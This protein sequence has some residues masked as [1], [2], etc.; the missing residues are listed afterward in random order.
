MR[1]DYLGFCSMVLTLFL[2]GTN[3]S[4]S[5][6]EDPL[7]FTSITSKE[8]LSSNIVHAILKDRYGLMWFGTEDGLNKFNGTEF[9]VYRYDPHN[10]FS[11]RSN[12]I[13]SLCEDKAGRLWIGTV[14]GALHR[15]DRNKD[16]FVPYGAGSGKNALSGGNIKGLCSDY[17]GKLW[18]ATL[19]GLNILDPVT[20]IVT[21]FTDN[22]KVAKELRDGIVLCL[23]ED[24]NKRMWIG[25]SS[26][27]YVYDQQKAHFRRFIHQ[28]DDTTSLVSN[29][30]KTI[31]QDKQGR[32]WIGTT[33]GL[34]MLLPGDNGFRNYK[35]S[36]NNTP[37]TSSDVIYSIGVKNTN[38]LWIGSEDGLNILDLHTYHIRQ[39]KPD[40]RNSFALTS[41]SIR[42]ILVDQQGI[43]WLGTY[44]GGVNKYDPNLTFFSLKKSNPFDPYGLSA[45]FVTSFSD[46]SNGNIFV[47]TDGGG[48]N[49]F[50]MQSKLLTHYAIR[51]KG[52][53]EAE[54]LAILSLAKAHDS[55]L[56]IGTYNDGFFKFYPKTGN[57]QQFIKEQTLPTLRQNDVFCLLEDSRGKLWIGTNGSGVDVFDAKTQK[58][59]RD[60]EIPAALD[61]RFLLSNGY[62]RTI[63]EDHNGKI[64]IGSYGN[65]LAVLDPVKRDVVFLDRNNG[66]LPSN[67]INALY[68]DPRGGMWVGTS[69]EGLVRLNPS[70][71]TVAVY[72]EDQGLANGVIHSIL[73]DQ[74][75]R[76]WVSTNVGVSWFDVRT[77][78]FT[79]Y[80]YF[81]GLQ[82]NSFVQGA[83]FTSKQG[84]LFFGGVE[85]INY[86]SPGAIKQNK[87]IPQVM[88][89]DLKLGGRSVT[90]LD[91]SVLS[92][93]ISV[94]KTI[95]L[96][97][98]Q[99]FSLSYVALN[100]TSPRQNQYS[101]RLK[102]FENEWNNAGSKTTANYTNL[103]PG[104]Y[105]FQVRVS[106]N[107]GVWNMRGKEI[108]IIVKP[109]L[110]MTWY[111]CISYFLFAAVLLLYIR[112]RGIRNLQKEFKAHQEKRESERLH[113]LDRLKIK[114]LTNLSHEFRTP[115]SLIMAPVD[116]LLVEPHNEVME[117]Q[118]GLI[119]RNAKRLLNLVNQLLDLRK[120]EEHESKLCTTRGDIVSFSREVS[121]SFKDISEKK[122]I[123]FI[124][125]TDVEKL[126]VYFD[127]DKI[128]R[129]LFNL[130]SNAFKFTTDGGNVSLSVDQD[131]NPTKR[132]VQILNIKVSDTG[133]GIPLEQQERI[134]GRFYQFGTEPAV[135]NQGSGIGLSIA[136]EFV[137][138]HGGTLTVKSEPGLGST[139]LIQLPFDSP[140]EAD[141]HSPYVPLASEVAAVPKPIHEVT[142]DQENDNK[143]AV[144]IVEDN[145][146]FRFYLKD[147]LKI[148]YKV[149]EAKDGKEGWQKAL[150]QHPDLV[151][152]D[153]MMPHMNGTALSLKL[154]SD[155]RTAHIPVILLTASTG[156]EEELRGLNSGANDYLTKPFKFDILNAKVKNLLSYN[157]MLKKT[158][159]KQVHLSPVEVQVESGNEAFVKAVASYIEENI[160]N[161]EL[162]VQNI[163]HHVSMS[164]GSL[165]NKLLE[166]TGQTPIEFIR[167][168]KLEKAAFLLEK[169]DMNI[170]QIAYA[171]GF[172]TPNYFAKSFKDK[173]GL[174]PSDYIK[175]K[176][177]LALIDNTRDR[178][179]D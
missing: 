5:A 177:K 141:E 38:E 166:T 53:G 147:N 159:V 161:R 102:G 29:T 85:G 87:H 3:L 168:M 41:K 17:K 129:V 119:Q 162:S 68:A 66:R 56:W 151:I 35:H 83:G 16:W 52:R 63:V 107:D 165:Y 140:D 14:G 31:T 113:E 25:T 89:T 48:L 133:I 171:V 50:H 44:E 132:Q 139:F 152:S 120:M 106:N 98:K 55:G 21:K 71:K 23:F 94:A 72:G 30:V 122:N 126:V 179:N 101:Y 90:A 108:K 69:G 138:L 67:K 76:I 43:C 148:F 58:F 164:R 160:T 170:A 121:E 155:S 61:A 79:N 114:F 175:Q 6:Q 174:L 128:E 158:Y 131:S 74:A 116:K 84:A 10:K 115:I 81:N 4:V 70:G 73:K 134:F 42:S 176:R 112:Y 32:L 110:W 157:R 104:E 34:S 130:L 136:K 117:V 46:D 40:Y 99:N 86:I 15:Y 82:N 19:S 100:Y 123:T 39:Y 92:E 105:V 154:K 95:H 11:L 37:R 149:I 91:S 8:G 80:S 13:S 7:N 33:G 54:H 173:Y 103:S 24:K 167:I 144:L 109:P 47:G 9:T 77:S 12:E 118:L 36:G 97:Y 135:L 18:I 1:S 145:D 49:L 153:V 150:F 146:D 124:F 111:A 75:G 96:D 62:I 127:A 45:P 156:E 88:F 28:N 27:L 143:P 59:I 169:S 57:Y 26:G 172:A 65:G 178:N 163:S 60:K 125:H 142:A 64:W 93:H 22:P 137:Q 78:R 51:A 20:N 2:V